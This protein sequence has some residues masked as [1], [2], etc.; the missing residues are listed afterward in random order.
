[1]VDSTKDPQ[2]A[3]STIVF[4]EL[5][6]YTRKLVEDGLAQDRKEIL[7]HIDSKF[8]EVRSTMLS[9]FPADD[10]VGHKAYHIKQMEFMEER[11]KLYKEIRSKTLVGLVWLGLVFMGTAALEHARS[12][13]NIVA[14]GSP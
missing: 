8:N 14:K 10:P 1:M 3:E 11:A 12:L 9:A 7:A 5:K 6:E 2:P 13:I 4:W